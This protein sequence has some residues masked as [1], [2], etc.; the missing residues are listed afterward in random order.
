MPEGQRGVRDTHF[1]PQTQEAI[2][3]MYDP[4]DAHTFYDFDES[5]KI[6][7][8]GY[9]HIYRAID[10]QT[11]KAVA[12]KFFSFSQ[13]RGA[14]IGRSIQEL[15]MAYVKL[16]DIKSP[17]ILPAT[18]VVSD[19]LLGY[20]LVTPWAEGGTLEEK[21]PEI[22]GNWETSASYGIQIALGLDALHS[23]GLVFR[24]LKPR[25]VFLLSKKTDQIPSCAIGDFGLSAPES[26]LQIEQTKD[27][28]DSGPI[29]DALH[30]HDE[31]GLW[32]ES[33]RL[34]PAIAKVGT[35]NYMSPEQARAQKISYPSDLFTLGVVL[36]K[37]ITGSH[38]LGDIGGNIMYITP[39][40]TPLPIK[41]PNKAD[42]YKE[43]KENMA[44]IIYALLSKNEEDRGMA[45]IREVGEQKKWLNH[46]KLVLFRKLE[47]PTKQIKLSTAHDVAR[48]L[49]ECWVGSGLD[50]EKTPWFKEAL[51]Q[52]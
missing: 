13:Y 25:N 6:S 50:I 28:S 5:N 2:E 34:T 30:E 17:Y 29:L 1:T 21:L 45:T 11:G 22:K 9:S 46:V 48:A 33:E 15:E 40:H 43:R 27:T 37:I 39:Y 24:D 31:D 8:T 19:D 44:N 14:R 7:T 10:K 4:R 41:K 18:D 12:I 23:N 20:G 3:W 36:Y 42:K 32:G 38:P 51:E 49:A 35:V 52:K 26:Y 16:R 47:I